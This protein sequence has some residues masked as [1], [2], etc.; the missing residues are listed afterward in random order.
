MQQS[1]QYRTPEQPTPTEHAASRLRTVM[2][3]RWPRKCS[4]GRGPRIPRGDDV[5]LV[6]DFG[7]S[8]VYPAHLLGHSPDQV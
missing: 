3:N 7:V 4:C 8:R 1:I 5:C 2:G 6:A